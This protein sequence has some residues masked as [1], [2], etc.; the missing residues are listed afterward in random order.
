MP[1]VDAVSHLGPRGAKD[2]FRPGGHRGGAL[3][4]QLDELQYTV[5]DRLA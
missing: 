4:S 2:R 1:G 5:I 3:L